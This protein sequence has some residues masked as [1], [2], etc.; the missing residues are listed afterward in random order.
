MHGHGMALEALD[1]RLG[2]R[3][4]DLAAQTKRRTLDGV[5]VEV[6]RTRSDG[7]VT[8][9]FDADLEEDLFRF[10]A[11]SKL[12]I[13]FSS[14]ERPDV[15]LVGS[16]ELLALVD[17][18]DGSSMAA[19]GYPGGS[20]AVSIVDMGTSK[21]LLSRIAEVFTGY[22]YSALGDV[23]LRDGVPIRPSGVRLAGDSLVVAYFASSARMELFRKSGIEWN[24]CRWVRNYGG[25]VD[26]AKVGSGQCDA[27]VEV[28][29][30]FVAREYV[31][32][33]HIATAAGATASTLDGLP[34]PVH[35]DR[36]VRSKFI[37]AATRELHAELLN[38][39]AQDSGEASS[40]LA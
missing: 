11:E 21:P 14:E 36:R 17:P 38:M 31:A 24:A 32:G 40:E 7:D 23:A 12:P 9:A 30:G 1:V 18:L 39:F 10:F 3:M 25:L 37:V 16:P 28:L 29:K 13:R 26:I 35:L 8:R 33:I 6:V 22:Q 5:G 4:M 20:I 34:V 27:M 2:S 15:D 19:R